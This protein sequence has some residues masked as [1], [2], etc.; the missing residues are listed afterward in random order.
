VA[1]LILANRDRW[2]IPPVTVRP[3]AAALGV[4]ETLADLLAARGLTETEAA[5]QYLDRHWEWR[6]EHWAW[7]ELVRATE[8]IAEAIAAHEPMAIYG[9]Y[10]VDG[11]TSTSVL[12]SFLR[13]L[14]ADVICY[15]PHRLH[16]GY[17]LSI[18]AL[19]KLAAMGRRLVITVD[20]GVSAVAEVA[21][22]TSIGLDVI[23]TDHHTP[24]DVLPEPLA[25]VNPKIFVPELGILAGVGV[26]YWLCLSLQRRLGRGDADA[27][28][29][30]VAIGS[31]ADQVPLTGVNR[32]LVHRGLAQMAVTRRLGVQAL[33]HRA[34]GD[35]Q[36]AITA[37]DIGFTI[38]PRLNAAGRLEHPQVAVDL[39]LAET[40]EQAADLANELEALNQRRRH[41]TDEMTAH[42]QEMVRQ[43]CSLDVDRFLTL[44]SPS[45]HHGVSGI[46]A[47]R[48][49]E[50]YQRP[51][52]LLCQDGDV[53]KGSGRC[54]DWVD[55]HG[56]LK[57]NQAHLMRFGGHRQAAGCTVAD[58]AKLDLRHGLNRA[59]R[60]SLGD[61]AAAPVPVDRI[62]PLSA[63]DARFVDELALL[64]PLGQK[65]PA[66]RLGTSGVRLLSANLRGAAGTTLIGEVTDGV[67]AF[68]ILGMG[69]IGVMPLPEIVDLVHTPEWNTFRGETKLQ[70]RLHAIGGET[71][72]E[73]P[74]PS[75]EPLFEEPKTALHLVDARHEADREALWLSLVAEGE[76]LAAWALTRHT[77]PGWVAGSDQVAIALGDQSP[78]KIATL[79]LFDP[80]VSPQVLRRWLDEAEAVRVVLLWSG[81]WAIPDPVEP[82]ALNLV[83]RQ[84]KTLAGRTTA[85]VFAS[86]WPQGPEVFATV[87]QAL[88]EA[89][90][91]LQDGQSWRL[92]SAAG[93][94]IEAAELPAVK[95]HEAMRM[96]WQAVNRAK[97][98][99]LL[100]V[101]LGERA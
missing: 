63:I 92:L 74:A 81:D 9:D 13:S 73:M 90:L 43:E 100:L 8:R 60:E 18:P 31:V 41:L 76:P 33:L 75:V 3:D 6:D 37:R 71:A 36:Q 34:G 10:D 24:P 72:V 12:L 65:N 59:M 4:S 87:W 1:H 95:R 30:I 70:L 11:V 5:R 85:A 89:G 16:D 28:L 68:R 35:S 78:P 50:A 64:E 58:A 52:M 62:V 19:D 46:V 94:R 27:L 15:L 99:D 56:L 61:L 84:L 80:P 26:A 42:A 82:G 25:M 49:V 14:G 51:V 44:W 40:E 22:A 23:I 88:R 57:A 54:P 29:D 83:Y 86:E 98:D 17:G 66:P 20:N 55:L 96:Y 69:A 48:L 101:L 21:H 93:A 2:Q 67:K 97:G 38:G 91:L 32:H 47:A 79:V 77:L 45:W 53:W 7:P 39:L